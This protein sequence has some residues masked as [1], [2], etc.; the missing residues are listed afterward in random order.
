MKILHIAFSGL[1]GHG[2][3]FFSM[4]DADKGK[5]HQFEIIFFG[6]EEVRE[7]Y[8]Q[9]ANQR[10]IPWYYVKKKPGFDFASYR[11]IE[12]I[13][14]QTM[15]DIIFLH[16]S[17]Y[18]FP[19]KKAI[20]FI[21]KKIKIIVRE[22]QPNHLKTKLNWLGLSVSLITA[23]KV[24]FLSTE[25]RDV[26]RKKLSLFFSERRTAVIPNGVDLEM[27]KPAEKK[28]H[29][30]IN[31]G[32]QSRLSETKDHATLIDAFALVLKSSGA[33]KLYIAG[34]GVCRAA[35]EKQAQEINISHAVEFT[36]M[37]EE[38]ALPQFIN[39]LDLYVHA[40]LGETMST[41]IMQVMA[42]RLPIIASDVLGVNNM[43]KHN[44]NGL[45]VPAKNAEAL[46]VAVL[47]FINEPK[48]ADELAANA[49][50][51]ASENYSNIKMLQ[52]YNEIFLN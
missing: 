48:L 11:Q 49:F 51:F 28:E 12:K 42:C 44:Q 39:S 30:G 24:V 27:Y 5:Q 45:L 21:S 2:N 15:P 13:I 6:N 50:T 47:Q 23:T 3:V 32:M 7:G 38:T 4:A 10:N 29:T 33:A 52:R 36:G 37:L 1:G 8:I 19:V 43:I 20:V 31:I 16:S 22:T 26:I 17:S 9:K 14:R 35:L 41:A 40:T 34:D 25:Y 46:S 18:I